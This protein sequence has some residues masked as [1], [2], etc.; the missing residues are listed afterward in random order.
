MGTAEESEV[1]SISANFSYIGVVEAYLNDSRRD[2]KMLD[3]YP[4]LK[5]VFM[6]FN[7]ILSSSAP[8]E[9]LFSISGLI[10]CARRNRLADSKFEKLV[11]IKGNR[12]FLNF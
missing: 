11:T 12:R 7:C 6:K 5:E 2:L 9:R 1:S 4:I 8:V 10:L 3:D